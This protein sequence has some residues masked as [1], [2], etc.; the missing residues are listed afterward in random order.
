MILLDLKYQGDMADF[1]PGR[2][3][4]FSRVI[5]G[6]PYCGVKIKCFSVEDK[7]LVTAKMS[8]QNQQ[9]QYIKEI[10]VSRFMARMLWLHGNV[11]GIK[12]G[13]ETFGLFLIHGTEKS[14][15]SLM[16]GFRLL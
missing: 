4:L 16:N 12:F 14:H 5:E 3:Q 11:Y 10:T 7:Y 13:C 1:R 15:L 6:T 8:M 2:R 9:L